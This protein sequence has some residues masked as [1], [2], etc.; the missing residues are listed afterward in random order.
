MLP[1]LYTELDI[2]MLPYLYTEL[3]VHMLP[4]LYTELYVHMLPYFQKQNM[5]NLMLSQLSIF[6][7]QYCTGAPFLLKQNSTDKKSLGDWE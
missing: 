4:Y 7:N 2:Q 6:H 1:Y 5:V 3:D